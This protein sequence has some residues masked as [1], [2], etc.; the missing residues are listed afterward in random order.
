MVLNTEPITG[1]V[2]EAHR[3]SVEDFIKLFL[4]I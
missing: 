3:S 2:T 4:M 1:A